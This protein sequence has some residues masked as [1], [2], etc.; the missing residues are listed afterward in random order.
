MFNYFRISKK[1][2]ADLANVGEIFV[3]K[4]SDDSQM[5]NKNH[6]YWV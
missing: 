6:T 3:N 2:S 1:S 5:K 4:A